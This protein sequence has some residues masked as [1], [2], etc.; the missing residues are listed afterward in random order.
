MSTL[1]PPSLILLATARVAL[2]LTL[3]LASIGCKSAKVG[4]PLTA[5]LAGAEPQTQ[6]EFWHELAN[7]PVTSND[8]A[9]HAVLIYLDEGRIE[10]TD[11]PGRVAALQSRGLLPADFN[12]P[13]ED[14]IRRG[15]MAVILVRAL[16]I[17]GGI[18]LRLWGVTRRYATRELEFRNIYTPSAT[19]QTFSGNEFVSLIGR[20]E[21]FQR[22][23]AAK[24][25]RQT[26]EPSDPAEP[27]SAPASAASP[28][29]RPDASSASEPPAD[30]TPAPEPDAQPMR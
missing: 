24:Q 30:V 10:A 17:K 11:Y 1:H 21:D 9:F 4:Q 23:A 22:Q 5:S 2:V 29:P 15:D 13:P 14:A 16:H 7:R 20:M 26:A 19:Y 18:N 12:R 25:A 3:A 6:M 28:D 8:E 27:A